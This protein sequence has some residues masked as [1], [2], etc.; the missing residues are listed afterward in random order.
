MRGVSFSDETMFPPSPRPPAP[1]KRK[2]KKTM[3]VVICGGKYISDST[4][5]PK[6]S[7]TKPAD[8][9]LTGQKHKLVVYM[10]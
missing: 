10:C 3:C 4:I 6:Y 9:K 1:G 8:N 7:I 2:K 5:A